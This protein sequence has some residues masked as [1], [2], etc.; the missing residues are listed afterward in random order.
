V[1]FAGDAALPSNPPAAIQQLRVVPDG[2]QAFA[3]SFSLIDQDGAPTVGEGRAVL[4]ISEGDTADSILYRQA[5]TLTVT[6]FH[7]TP[8][9]AGASGPAMFVADLGHIPYSAFSRPPS[10]GSGQ[11]R[12]SFYPVEGGAILEAN[13]ALTFVH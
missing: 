6:D 5:I 2:A 1:F 11:A 12:L 3:A 8:G 13:A 9:D 4:R 10:G 7:R